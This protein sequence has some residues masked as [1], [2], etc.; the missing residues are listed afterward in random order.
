MD[1]D[2]RFE[3]LGCV[4]FCCSDRTCAVWEAGSPNRAVGQLSQAGRVPD[5]L[6]QSGDDDVELGPVAA[7]LLPA[8]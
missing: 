3:H 7:A 5:Q 1:L 8:A 4:F 6:V 2:R